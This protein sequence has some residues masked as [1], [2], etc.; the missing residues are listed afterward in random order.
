ML[1]EVGLMWWDM[2]TVEA[3]GIRCWFDWEVVEMTESD[4]RV[5]S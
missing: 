3:E 1:T 4:I 5:E 2:K